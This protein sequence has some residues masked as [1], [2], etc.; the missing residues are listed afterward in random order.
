MNQSDKS[1]ST[2]CVIVNGEN[3]MDIAKQR[4]TLKQYYE[5]V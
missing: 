5:D 3:I 4:Q 2:I 1:N